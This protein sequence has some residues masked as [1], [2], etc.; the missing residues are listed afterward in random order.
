[1]GRY[2]QPSEISEAK[3]LYRSHPELKPKGQRPV[4]SKPIGSPPKHLT[5]DEKA[6]WKELVK[7]LPP[8]V[9]MYSDR[10]AMERLVHLFDKQRKHIITI[11]EGSQLAALFA[12][13]GMTP[14]ARTRIQVPSQDSDELEVFLAGSNGVQ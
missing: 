3:G 2:P 9:A 8:G 5:A 14:A 7:Q 13:F 12:Q 11:G 10:A 1:M 4:P 6:I